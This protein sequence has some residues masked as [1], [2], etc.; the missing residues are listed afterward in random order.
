VN[1]K[2]SLNLLRSVLTGTAITPGEDGYDDA[3]ATW[4]TAVEHRP[5]LVV[6]P[7]TSSD[8]VAAVQYAQEHGLPV[9]VQGTGHGPI[10]GCTD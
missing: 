2:Q 10:F 9:A 4:D 3:R 1:E 7:E 8:V 5:Q 6:M